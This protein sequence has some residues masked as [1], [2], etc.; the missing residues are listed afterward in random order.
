M[1]KALFVLTALFSAAAL[2][3][4]VKA[5]ASS[6]SIVLE[7]DHIKV[8][9]IRSGGKIASFVDKSSKIDLL[10][11]S[12]GIHSGLGRIRDDLGKSVGV[13][14]G[15]RKLTLKVNTPQKAVVETVYTARGGIIDGLEITRQYIVKADSLA[16]DIVE[17]YRSTKRE[18][19]FAITWQNLFPL[20]KEVD[21]QDITLFT[22]DGSL[23]LPVAVQNRNNYIFNN[24]GSFMGWVSKKSRQGMIL[25]IDQDNYISSLYFWG[26][27]SNYT[28]ESN[29]K[30]ITLKPIV[31]LDHWVI[32]GSL[33]PFR[34]QGNVLAATRNA[35]AVSGEKSGKET[36]R[37]FWVNDMSVGTV[38]QAGTV[39]KTSA[40]KAGKSVEIPLQKK[41]ETV[42]INAGDLEFKLLLPAAAVRNKQLTAYKSLPKNQKVGVQGFYYFYPTL[43]LSNEIA[44]E[45]YFGLRGNFKTKKNFRMM[46]ALPENVHIDYTPHAYKAQ[47]SKV[48]A[49]KSYKLYAMPSSRRTN[50]AGA[51]RLNFTVDK[52]FKGGEL[53][54]YAAWDGGS[55]APNKINLQ[56]IKPLPKV[57][58][59]LKKLQ[60]GLNVCSDV[61]FDT[62]TVKMHDIETS[63]YQVPE[64]DKLGLQFV[65]FW[66]YL[67]KMSIERLPDG[68]FNK[69]IKQ[70]KSRGLE[71]FIELNNAYF[72]VREAVKGQM[73]REIGTLTHPEKTYQRI[74]ASEVCA[75]DYKGN[76][77]QYVCPSNR[78]RYFERTLDLA[79][80]AIDYGF[81]NLF[82]DEEAWSNAV[83]VC[84]CERCKK[85]FKEF[86]QKKYP[87]VP[88]QDPAITVR[89]PG[90]HPALENAWW[91][92]KTDLVAD[93]YQRIRDLMESY[94]NPE[95]KQRKLYCWLSCSV[96]TTG[97]Y[98]AITDRM[99][100]YK[101]LGNV[102]DAI[103]PMIY[104][105]DANEIFELTT[106]AKKLLENK[107][108]KLII[109]LCPHRYYEYFRVEAQS[110]AID[111]AV[112]DQILEAIF[113]GADGVTFWSHRG[114][115]RGAE[116][117]RN[118]ALAIKTLIP[119][120]DIITEGKTVKM[121]SSNPAVKVTA[122]QYKGEYAVFL[123]NYDHT[124]VRT[125]FAIPKGMEAID[126][127]TGKKSNGNLTF[128]DRRT[129]V[130]KL[131]KKK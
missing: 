38:K 23:P 63:D 116:D 102:F 88:Y 55:Q 48:I 122:W 94:R 105:D 99:T 11:G 64:Y 89:E 126:T 77:A 112:Y 121:K 98:G 125:R 131:E 5:A 82:Y 109:G 33:V 17:T 4:S 43:Y 18:N 62:N 71:P 1:K 30:E 108:S 111:S 100:D 49:G 127:L 85:L 14:V 70:A 39:H 117:M 72:R 123:R 42:E 24:S 97:R 32:S 29:F 25:R 76:R 26:S 86:L 129:V 95:K 66:E 51:L 107:R 7:N 58:K 106:R 3:A 96:N 92:F 80:L 44:T 27:P 15:S 59:G 46:I 28:L 8:K 93:I 115:F 87:S 54:I 12:S 119:V 21:P 45:I 56:L 74:T 35:L 37:V 128:G 6:G 114:G 40:S 47:G 10:K 9:I 120:E 91:D 60:M 13:A 81:D 84:F 22:A 73:A 50:Y 75:V 16:L 19:R 61:H 20:S 110:F 130:L 83:E 36:V 104:M 68:A 53:Y 90:K 78:G 2:S 103:F 113:A 52:S 79:K 57:G 124:T 69:F 31:G 67:P 34:G 118:M 101:K 41:A 65:E